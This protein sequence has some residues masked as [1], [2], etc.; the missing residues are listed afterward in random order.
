MKECSKSIPRRLHDPNFLNRYF[1]GDGLDIGGRPDPLV[2]YR[3]QFCQMRS[4]RTWDLEDGDAQYMEGVPDNSFDFVHS[5]HTLEHLFDPREGLR[6]WLRILRAGGH[7]IVTVPDEDLY[8]QGVFPSTFNSDHKWT[9]TVWKVRSWSK[10]SISIID[11]IRELG[12]SAELIRLEQLSATYRF[13]LPRYDQT[14]TP[15]GECGIEFVIRKR[16]V[17]EIEDGGR[18]RRSEKQPDRETRTLLN[19]YRDDMLALKQVNKSSPPFSND[20]D[21]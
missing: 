7:L 15:T 18:W 13:N 16:S 17:T 1:V 2:L 12:E 5:S 3:E 11:L 6:N 4:V 8:E 20:S 10:R 19:Q 14:L 9:F 21:L